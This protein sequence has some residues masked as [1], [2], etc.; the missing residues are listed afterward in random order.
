MAKIVVTTTYE[1]DSTSAAWFLPMFFQGLAGR[2]PDECIITLSKTGKGCFVSENRGVKC[3][4]QYELIK[5][6]PK[7]AAPPTKIFITE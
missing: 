5:D 4:T 2:V 3:D 6:P 7:V 1:F